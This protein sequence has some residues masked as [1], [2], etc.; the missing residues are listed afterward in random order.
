MK[1]TV[2]K[3]LVSSIIS[4]LLCLTLT[5]CDTQIQ[6]LLE[7]LTPEFEEII[8]TEEIVG[9]P[10]IITNGGETVIVKKP[11]A[12]KGSDNSDKNSKKSDKNSSKK[13]T[14]SKKSNN[15]SKT[16]SNKSDE[17]ITADDGY[18]VIITDN[19]EDEVII[20]NDTPELNSIT[21][22]RDWGPYASGKN[23]AHDNFNNHL[24]KIEKDPKSFLYIELCAAVYAEK[25]EINTALDM[26][27]YFYAKK[28]K[29]I[30]VP[31]SFCFY[32]L[33]FS[34]C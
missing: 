16:T 20:D 11:S 10:K 32:N 23:A 25:N 21:I 17:I 14:E 27:N 18:E 19:D 30:L 8:T 2:L 26:I 12:K 24:K 22:V 29:D 1:I 4:I 5:G 7:L 33:H 31:L 15:S 34:S 6:E 3:R 13:E 28:D 9:D